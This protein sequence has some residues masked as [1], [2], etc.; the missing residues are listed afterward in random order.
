MYRKSANDQRYAMCHVSIMNELS[1]KIQ[2]HKAITISNN[3][4][5]VDW[6]L[7]EALAQKWLFDSMSNPYYWSM[8]FNGKNPLPS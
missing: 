2:R 4:R 5:H 8:E 6:L 1:E 3:F 7:G